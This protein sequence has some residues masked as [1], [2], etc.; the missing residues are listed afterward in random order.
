[1]FRA[2]DL[3][4]SVNRSANEEQSP[5]PAALVCRNDSVI[6]GFQSPQYS[7][8]EKA[9]MLTIIAVKT[10]G[11]RNVIIAAGHSR[12]LSFATERI[13]AKNI[14]SKRW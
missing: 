5:L 12:L 13:R 6:S 10:E 9:R 3:I 4:V 2:F 8:L 1:M 11:L 7:A 14:L